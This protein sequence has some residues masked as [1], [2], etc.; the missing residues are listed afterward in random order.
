MKN[1]TLGLILP[2]AEFCG[3]VTATVESLAYVVETNGSKP[4]STALM[5]AFCGVVPAFGTSN[6]C[7]TLVMIPALT[8]F[9]NSAV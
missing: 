5:N 2:I 7:E 3:S 6:I 4:P 8:V 1:S 9:V